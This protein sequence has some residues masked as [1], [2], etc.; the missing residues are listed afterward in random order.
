MRRG[1][2]FVGPSGWSYPSWTHTVAKGVRL[3]DRLKFVSRLFNA[4]EVNGSFYVQIAPE[5][6]RAWRDT[7]PPGFRF[8]VKGHRYVTHYKRLHDCRDPVRRLR[9][10]AGAL[11]D[12]LAAVLWQLPAQIGRA[13]V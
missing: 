12:K 8:A 3:E 4:A 10:Q 11:G 5:T 2:I 9:A 7:T 1:A 13:H 6:Y